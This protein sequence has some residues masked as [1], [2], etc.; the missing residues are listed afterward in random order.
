MPH[1]TGPEAGTGADST[2]GRNVL[3]MREVVVVYRGRV[4]SPWEARV[5]FW[6]GVQSGAGWREAVV[7]AL[8]GG[9]PSSG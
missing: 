8:A 9:F 7:A 5:V 2:G 1:R 3:G 4:R 6:D